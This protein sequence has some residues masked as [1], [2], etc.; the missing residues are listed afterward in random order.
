MLPHGTSESAFQ[1]LALLRSAAREEP[2]RFGGNQSTVAEKFDEM[3]A[4][5][6]R[7]MFCS[8]ACLS[9]ATAAGA[10][11]HVAARVVQSDDALWARAAYAVASTGQGLDPQSS[12]GGL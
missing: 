11:A 4:L 8:G 10:A 5:A 3:D 7:L 6:L 12:G 1:L 2:G 9:A